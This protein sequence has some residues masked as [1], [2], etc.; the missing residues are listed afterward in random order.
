M[1]AANYVGDETTHVCVS[2]IGNVSV[3]GPG[4]RRAKET[5]WRRSQPPPQGRTYHSNEHSS[6]PVHAYVLLV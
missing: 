2:V 6:I 3:R 4:R 5:I 1:A